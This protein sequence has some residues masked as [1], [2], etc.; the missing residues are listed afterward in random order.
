MVG[1][2]N[3]NIVPHMLC[4]ADINET[5]F[6]LS[7]QVKRWLLEMGCQQYEDIFKKHGYFKLSFIAGM[8]AEVLLLLIS[9][10]DFIKVHRYQD[11]KYIGIK[12]R[13]HILRLERA[14]KDLKYFVFKKPE[15]DVSISTHIYI[16][17]IIWDSFHENGPSFISIK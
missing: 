17:I 6:Q 4:I 13:G 15:N 12:I 14:A 5:Q 8:T 9:F 3:L 7:D 16:Y 2:N 10:V 1:T 11:L